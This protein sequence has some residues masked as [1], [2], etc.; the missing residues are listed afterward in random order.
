[1][2]EHSLK[3]EYLKDGADWSVQLEL[4]ARGVMPVGDR[5]GSDVKRPLF[6]PILEAEERELADGDIPLFTARANGR[7]LDLGSD[8]LLRD[9][10]IDGAGLALDRLNALDDADLDRQ[11][12]AIRSALNSPTTLAL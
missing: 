11:L 6:W 4:L 8:H 3:P 9:C 1:V 12:D 7:S 5:V 2:L 10:V